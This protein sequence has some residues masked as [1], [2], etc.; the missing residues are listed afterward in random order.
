[1]AWTTTVFSGAQYDPWDK[2]FGWTWASG[3]GYSI[4][5]DLDGRINAIGAGGG[6]ASQTY[7]FD[8]AWRLTGI[9]RQPA[10]ATT[11][12]GYDTRDRLLSGTTWGSYTYD[13]NSNRLT[14]LGTLGPQSYGMRPAT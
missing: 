14:W 7:A 13:A 10:N 5:Y 9:T 8:T 1:M 3:R 12:F 6:A 2:L 11:T 4:S